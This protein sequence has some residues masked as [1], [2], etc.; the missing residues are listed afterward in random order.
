MT[1]LIFWLFWLTF[2]LAV[3]EAQTPAPPRDDHQ[4]WSEMQIIKPL[5]KD[6]DLLVIGVLR[7]GRE[8]SRPVDERIGAGIAF[9][10]RKYLTLTPTYIYVDQQPFEGRRI[11]EHRL[12]F[13]ATGKLVLGK[14]TFTDRNLYER[15]VRHNS[16]DFTMYRNRLQ[17][18][19]PARLG[20]F[21]F[22]PFIADEVFYSSQAHP[23]GGNQ[24]WFRNRIAAGILKQF[25][26]RYYAEFFY[27]HQHDGISRPGNVH[28]LGTLF[29]VILD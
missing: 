6:K 8:V 5:A 15:R 19:H 18:D 21:A 29:R 12:I 13:N 11:N 20:Q 10:L 28:A 23:N 2:W 3:A 16:R 24:G 7:L 14:F 1:K 9:K 4:V 25:S 22:K 26:P 17:L 27:L